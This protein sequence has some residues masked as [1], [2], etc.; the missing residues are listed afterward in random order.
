MLGAIDELATSVTMA[1]SVKRTTWRR[2]WMCWLAKQT[3]C[4]CQLAVRRGEFV[5]ERRVEA[6]ERAREQQRAM[7]CRREREARRQRR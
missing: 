1:A 2:W 5:R 6:S 7:W 4:P 3:A